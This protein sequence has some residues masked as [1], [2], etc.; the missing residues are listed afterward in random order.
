MRSKCP[1][2]NRFMKS[3][4]LS[5]IGGNDMCYK[6]DLVYDYDEPGLFTFDSWCSLTGEPIVKG[7][8]EYC[9]RIYKMK[10]FI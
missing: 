9:C 1:R 2:C 6:C 4:S 3:S 7:D 5:D 10:A 8:F